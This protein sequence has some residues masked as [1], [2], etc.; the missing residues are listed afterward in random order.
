[1]LDFNMIA[2]QLEELTEPTM[3]KLMKKEEGVVVR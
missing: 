1:V 2:N 3:T